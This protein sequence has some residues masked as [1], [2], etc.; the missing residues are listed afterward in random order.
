M[1]GAS[2][3][4]N[5]TRRRSHLSSPLFISAYHVDTKCRTCSSL[6]SR[7]TS[8]FRRRLTLVRFS[9]PLTRA[10]IL[11]LRPGIQE[12][13]SWWSSGLVFV[14]QSRDTY[15]RSST[16]LDPGRPFVRAISVGCYLFPVACCLWL[17]AY[18]RMLRR[19]V[20]SGQVM[21]DQF[22]SSQ[23]RSGIWSSVVGLRWSVVASRHLGGWDSVGRSQIGGAGR[24][25]KKEEPTK[26]IESIRAPAG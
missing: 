14:E 4:E 5:R 24:G 20:G 17:V 7:S 2:S 13:G 10:S 8:F 1:D 26:A 18:F 3:Y 6:T 21:L 25:R 11:P 23:I 16:S 12:A 9:R 22:R 15:F 19:E